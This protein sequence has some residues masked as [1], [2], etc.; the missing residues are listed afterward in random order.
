MQ[1]PRLL[2]K[3]LLL[4]DISSESVLVSPDTK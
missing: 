2:D 4:T 3:D 1:I